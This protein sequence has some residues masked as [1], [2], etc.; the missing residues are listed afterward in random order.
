MANGLP[1]GIGLAPAYGPRCPTLSLNSILQHSTRQKARN[2]LE[3]SF[4]QGTKIPPGRRNRR[5][6]P[7][8]VDQMDGRPP[9][10]AGTPSDQY[11][12]A[13]QRRQFASPGLR[14]V[15]RDR[16]SVPDRVQRRDGNSWRSSRDLAGPAGNES[17]RR[18]KRKCLP[19]ILHT[20]KIT[21]VHG[22]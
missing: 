4:G 5:I 3:L 12:Q 22:R 13:G 6:G 21:F 2:R 14:R 9:S 8:G 11:P 15:F 16:H 10:S 7:G 1:P 17:T 18:N 19:V 20:C